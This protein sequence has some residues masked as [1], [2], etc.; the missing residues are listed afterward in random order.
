MLHNWLHLCSSRFCFLLAY[1]DITHSCTV[2]LSGVLIVPQNHSFVVR[3]ISC[4]YSKAHTEIFWQDLIISLLF[5]HTC[6]SIINY[7][8]AITL[9][10][11]P[12]VALHLL[13]ATGIEHVICRKTFPP[14]WISLFSSI[15]WWKN[16]SGP[17]RSR[18][19]RTLCLSDSSFAH[20]TH[21]SI[22]MQ[23]PKIIQVCCVSVGIPLASGRYELVVPTYN[24]KFDVLPRLPTR[25]LQE[26]GWMMVPAWHLTGDELTVS[27]S[28]SLAPHTAYASRAFD[29]CSR[30]KKCITELTSTMTLSV[31]SFFGAVAI[32][33][34]WQVWVV[35]AHW[36]WSGQ[37][38]RY[39]CKHRI[40]TS[41]GDQVLIF[42]SLQ[43]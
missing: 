35:G 32:A 13:L 31:A 14:V 19:D 26:M 40:L 9:F 7:V 30:Q 18:Y 20:H 24:D 29:A 41:S 37:C 23:G 27:P 17:C 33:A 11:A 36:I 21:L 12:F 34:C 2:I 6:Y 38:S 1:A 43:L 15:P 8:F 10:I 39:R 28:A 4:S 16:S 25:S 42:V 22:N 5:L 3:S